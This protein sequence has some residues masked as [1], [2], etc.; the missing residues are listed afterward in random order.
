MWACT[1]YAC[2]LY[3]LMG[4][5]ALA[6][7]AGV[8]F[9]HARLFAAITGMDGHPLWIAA[10]AGVLRSPQAWVLVFAPLALAGAHLAARRSPRLRWRRAAYPLRALF[11]FSIVLLVYRCVN[12][13]VAVFQPWDR[14][15]VLAALDARLWLGHTPAQWLDGI[16][17]PPLTWLM[18]GAYASWFVLVYATVW[19]MLQHSQQAAAEYV[20]TAVLAFYLGYLT[21]LLVP[22]IGPAYT[23]PFRHPLSG[24]VGLFT[25]GQARLARDCFPSLHTGLAVVMATSVWRYR[26]RWFPWYAALTAAI[27]LSTM[28]LRFHYGIDVV[29]G[30]A[31]GCVTAYIGPVLTRA[32][33][34]RQLL[35]AAARAWPRAGRVATV[36]T[37]AVPGSN[38]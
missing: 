21:Y 11:S 15:E 4:A 2:E 34:Q 22:A 14:D 30:A 37:T 1:W 33:R 10:L 25:Q 5:C 32:W 31:L 23:L 16:V 29:A 17:S 27:I 18:C 12:A 35:A 20:N 19:V 7:V 26:R 38:Y 28:Y 6:A 13:Y 9:T 3:E 24:L 8:F 36:A